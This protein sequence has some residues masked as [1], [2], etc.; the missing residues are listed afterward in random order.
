MHLEKPKRAQRGRP[1]SFDKSQLVDTV[2]HKFWQNG[3]AAVSLNEIA[4]DNGL[5]RASLYH[6]FESKEALFM[7]A[8]ERYLQDSPD[9]IF[10]HLE[11]P[12]SVGQCLY[13]FFDALCAMRAGDDLRR[14]CFICNCVDELVAVDGP[15]GDRIREL[16]NSRRERLKGLFRHAIS[17]GELPV[18]SNPVLLTH[19]FLNFLFGLNTFS[20]TTAG[21]YEMRQLCYGFLDSLGF[22]RQGLE[23]QQRA[24]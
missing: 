2:M 3:Y 13:N 20:K 12:N 9:A 11:K 16:L 8:L 6:S 5:T 24:S 21:E 7:L 1:I 4:K 19:M 15:L 14:G 17:T 10:D 18:N 23:S 22:S